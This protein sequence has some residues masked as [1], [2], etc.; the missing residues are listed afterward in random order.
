MIQPRLF[1]HLS[2]KLYFSS[3]DIS[4][5]YKSLIGPGSLGSS[6][7]YIMPHTVLLYV[8][9]SRACSYLASSMFQDH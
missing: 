7:V 5:A 2:Y 3:Y 1:C 9:I 8:Y 4:C 6:A